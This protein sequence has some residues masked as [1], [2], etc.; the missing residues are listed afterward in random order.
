MSR[1]HWGYLLTDCNYTGV[2]SHALSGSHFETPCKNKN[3]KKGK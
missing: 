1:S 2:I 3:R